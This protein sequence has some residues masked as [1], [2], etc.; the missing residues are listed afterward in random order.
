MPPPPEGNQ[1]S[2]R[3]SNLV[4]LSKNLTAARE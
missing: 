1:D 3:D 4:L 2:D